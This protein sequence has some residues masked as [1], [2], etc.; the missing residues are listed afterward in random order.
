MKK[1]RLFAAACF[2]ASALVAL[3]VQAETREECQAMVEA[4][5]DFCSKNAAE[6]CFE[7]VNKGDQFKKGELF[8]FVFDFEGKSL[9]NGGIPAMI[10]KNMANAKS[11][12][13]QLFIQEQIKVAKGGG[14]WLEYDWMNPAT[15]KVQKKVSYVKKVNDTFY[16]GAGIHE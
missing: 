9:A 13:G 10:G 1:S 16:L 2:A 12:D 6:V 11:A 14:G 3:P 5:V 8:I 7:A 15:K 4:A